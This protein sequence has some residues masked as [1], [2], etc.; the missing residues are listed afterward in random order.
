MDAKTM[1]GGR[2]S[3]GGL[4]RLSPQDLSNLRVEARGLPMHVAALAI[5][6]GAPLRDAQ[7]V[8]RLEAMRAEIERRLHLAPRLRQVLYRPPL[9]LGRLLWVDDADFDIGRHVRVRAIAPPGDETALLAACQELNEPALERSQPLWELW[10]LTGL[11]GGRVG[12]LIRLHHV[13]ADGVATV[14]LLGSL[15][16]VAPDT[17]PVLAPP[18]VPAAVPPFW[19]LL[20]DSLRRR[21]AALATAF[22]TLARP[23]QWLRHLRAAAAPLRESFGEG[24]ASRSSLNGPIGKYRRLL[25]VRAD[26]DRAKAVAHAHGAKVNDVVLAVVTGGTR[27]LLRSRGELVPGLLLRA[28][29]PVSVRGSGDRAAMGNLTGLMSVPLPVNEPDP[30]R[31]LETIARVTVARKRR[32]RVIRA[33]WRGAGPGLTWFMHHQ[34]LVNLLV[35]NVPGPPAPLSF[36][37]ARILEVF[38]LGVIQGNLRLSVGVLSY[39]GQLNFGILADAEAFPDLAVFAKGLGAALTELGV[40]APMPQRA[41]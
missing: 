27:A 36:A 37:G 41:A 23:A 32:R 35:S 12:M 14:A 8:F 18:W 16:D 1:S 9:G 15:F 19:E 25:V 5:L 31:R 30:V 33:W 4:Y 40:A 3:A 39:A 20:V 11:A 10:F 17:Q 7:G 21:G 13:V 28:S 38:Q 2:S 6:D 34:R 26:L 29:V 22:S 24:L